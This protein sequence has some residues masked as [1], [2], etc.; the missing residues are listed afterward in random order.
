LDSWQ[1][2]GAIGNSRR[3]ANAETII[4]R[5]EKVNR[6]S[7]VVEGRWLPDMNPHGFTE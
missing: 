7:Q 1:C 2:T 6:K 4:G 5:S 3:H